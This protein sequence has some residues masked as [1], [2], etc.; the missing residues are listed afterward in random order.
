[1]RHT[2]PPQNLLPFHIFCCLNVCLLA[3]SLP[4][5][6][7]LLSGC[8]PGSRTGKTNGQLICLF[9]SLVSMCVCYLSVVCLLSGSLPVVWLF[10]GSRVQSGD[11]RA[12]QMGNSHQLAAPDRQTFL[13]MQPTDSLA[14]WSVVFKP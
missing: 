8:F 3:E 2:G 10:P 5:R 7:R 11:G 1:M 12:R 4:N 6:Q 9:L 14:S 13:P